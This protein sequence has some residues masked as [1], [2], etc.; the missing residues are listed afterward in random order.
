MFL[1]K[2]KRI[3]KEALKLEIRKNTENIWDQF[4]N[5]HQMTYSIKLSLNS[6]SDVNEDVKL[7][8]MPPLLYKYCKRQGTN[9]MLKALKPNILKI[10]E[11][12]LSIE[13]SLQ[14][15][16]IQFGLEK[17]VFEMPNFDDIKGVRQKC[18]QCKLLLQTFEEEIKTLEKEKKKREQ[19]END[20]KDKFEKMNVLCRRLSIFFHDLYA[21][22]NGLAIFENDA[23]E[24]K[25]K[26]IIPEESAVLEMLVKESLH[27]QYIQIKMR[28]VLGFI[29]RL[30]SQMKTIK[31]EVDFTVAEV[32]EERAS[33]K[34]SLD[35]P[36]E[37]I[38]D[39]FRFMYEEILS[40][41]N[42][43]EVLLDFL[44][45]DE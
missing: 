14:N 45:D 44:D 38:H 8:E 35:N 9:D 27:F 32:T 18:N 23:C 26:E 6:L 7:Q 17:K 10:K 31:T 20:T 16:R 22:E 33:P 21:I 43:F 19:N 29:E 15:V 39:C 1:S 12:A 30:K 28:N 36:W 13:Q 34:F 4:E 3:E 41:K 5:V 40:L 25:M 42:D 11:D 24:N 37:S 2:K